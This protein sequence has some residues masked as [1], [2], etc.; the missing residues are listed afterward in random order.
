MTEDV[1]DV[2]GESADDKRATCIQKDT[3]DEI[4]ADDVPHMSVLEDVLK[5]SHFHPSFR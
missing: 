2:N 4:H 5:S 1:P 3:L